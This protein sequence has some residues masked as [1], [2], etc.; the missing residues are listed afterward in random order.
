MI[1]DIVAYQ[2]SDGVLHSSKELAKEHE[3]RKSKILV[4]RE[5]V[6]EIVR[7][8]DHLSFSGLG[9]T[10][11]LQSQYARLG[12]LLYQLPEVD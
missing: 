11:F 1:K 12:N 5:L 8:A 3:L 9:D 6:K 2:T 10:K 7:L 4:D